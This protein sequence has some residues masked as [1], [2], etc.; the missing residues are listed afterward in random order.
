MEA[1]G[2]TWIRHIPQSFHEYLQIIFARVKNLSSSREYNWPNLSK[3]RN[4]LFMQVISMHL[5]SF[6]PSTLLIWFFLRSIRDKCSSPDRPGGNVF[7]LL[8]DKSFETIWWFNIPKCSWNRP[9]RFFLIKTRSTQKYFHQ[10]Q[11]RKNWVSFFS[12]FKQ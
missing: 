10:I 3:L 2:R 8:S 7:S 4:N 5:R 6:I 9:I 12:I 11:I 1:H